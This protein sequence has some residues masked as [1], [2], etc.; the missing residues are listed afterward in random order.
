MRLV[1]PRDDEPDDDAAPR[2]EVGASLDAKVDAAILDVRA[3]HVTA[4]D[5]R[6]ASRSARAIAG[7]VEGCVARLSGD[8]DAARAETRAIGAAL[9]DLEAAMVVREARSSR[10]V[11][12]RTAATSGGAVAGVYV[13]IEIARIWLGS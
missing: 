2:S 5:A 10:D 9:A 1:V 12:R 11:A 3:L 4:R 6:D 8:I 13:A 7:R